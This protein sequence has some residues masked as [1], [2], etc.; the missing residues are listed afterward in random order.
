MAIRSAQTTARI[1]QSLQRG[2]PKRSQGWP[3][4]TPSS[5]TRLVDSGGPRLLP[6]NTSVRLLVSMFHT[7]TSLLA[8]VDEIRQD[9]LRGWADI[10]STARSETI[11]IK[12]NENKRNSKNKW[13]LY[14]RLH[15]KLQEWLQVYRNPRKALIKSSNLML[16]ERRTWGEHV[17]SSLQ[18]LDHCFIV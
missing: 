10:W 15:R 9:W 6:Q 2:L 1:M 8:P 12:Y 13:Q 3:G 14:S 17:F 11:D 4:H 18:A 5:H 7:L 16:G